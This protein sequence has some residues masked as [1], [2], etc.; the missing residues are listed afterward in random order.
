MQGYSRLREE[1]LR[2]FHID[3]GQ[4]VAKRHPLAVEKR[5]DTL[6]T[7]PARLARARWMLD[8]IVRLYGLAERYLH[9]STPAYRRAV[10]L[11]FVATAPISVRAVAFA[12]NVRAK[13]ERIAP[14]VTAPVGFFR[15]LTTS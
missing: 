12:R 10:E 5:T 3:C 9:R 11:R 7:Q 4:R 8:G 15:S 2:P 13:S 1:Q 6:L 14:S